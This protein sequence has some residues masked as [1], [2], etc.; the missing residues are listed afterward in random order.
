MDTHSDGNG[1]ATATATATI[2]HDTD[3]ELDR[4]E[5]QPEPEYAFR[6]PQ[7][8]VPPMRP[9][10]EQPVTWFDKV[11]AFVSRL[12]VRDNFWHSVCSLIW[13]PL[14]FFSGIKMKQLDAKTFEAS[15]PFRRFNRNWYRALAG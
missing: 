1:S 9:D 5:G 12:S 2:P 10:H 13:L 14:A 7:V 15:L 4:V 8:R 11:E 6:G 3:D